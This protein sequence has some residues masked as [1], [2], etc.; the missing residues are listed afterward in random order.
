MHGHEDL[1]FI[2]EQEGAVLLMDRNA[3]ERM[4]GREA[5]EGQA[6][7]AD[8][9]VEDMDGFGVLNL[10]QAVEKVRQLRGGESVEIARDPGKLGRALLRRLVEGKRAVET[11]DEGGVRWSGYAIEADLVQ[12]I[13]ALLGKARLG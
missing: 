5:R 8:Y 12:D 4:L 9:H 1:V 2:A 6:E 13:E 3:V 7:R 10:E 11:E